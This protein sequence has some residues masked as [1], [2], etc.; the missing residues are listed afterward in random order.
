MS[1]GVHAGWCGTWASTSYGSQSRNEI[2]GIR[3]QLGNFGRMCQCTGAMAVACPLPNLVLKTSRQFSSFRKR[4]SGEIGM[5]RSIGRIPC[6][7]MA[8]QRDRGGGD[9]L[10]EDLQE[11]VIVSSLVTDAPQVKHLPLCFLPS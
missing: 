10:S 8:G 4:A 3:T 2:T 7:V 6:I 1:Q 9:G 11:D 5:K